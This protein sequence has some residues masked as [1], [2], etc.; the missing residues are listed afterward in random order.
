MEKPCIKGLNSIDMLSELPFYHELNTGKISK[1]FKEYVRSYSIEII[2]SQDPSVQLTISKPS[3]KDF[4]KDLLDEIKGFKYQVTLKLLLSKYKENRYTEFT[5]VYF[6][7]TTKT[8]ISPNKYGL[9]KSL[10]EV[11]EK[12]DNCISEGS[13]WIIKMLNMSIF[14]FTVHYQEVHTLNYLIN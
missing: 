10:Q 14:L 4:S 5:T 1:T 13:G 12:I 2:D 11:F 3:I 7:S 6:N 8:K 9:N